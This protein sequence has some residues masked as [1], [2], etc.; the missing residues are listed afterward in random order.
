MAWSQVGGG[1]LR[2]GQRGAGGD[3]YI[4][5]PVNAWEAC[6]D[7]VQGSLRG[8]QRAALSAIIP[9]TIPVDATTD[10]ILYGPGVGPNPTVVIVPDDDI[11]IDAVVFLGTG[12]ARATLT[13]AADADLIT[14]QVSVVSDLGTTNSLGLV[15]TE[16][17]TNPITTVQPPII[18]AEADFGVA[19]LDG[20]PMTDW[21]D[22]SGHNPKFIAAAGVNPPIFHINGFGGTP[23]PYWEFDGGMGATG[24]LDVGGQAT[25]NHSTFTAFIVGL[26]DG[27]DTTGAWYEMQLAAHA[28]LGELRIAAPHLLVSRSGLSSIRTAGAPVIDADARITARHEFDGTHNGH[29]LFLNGEQQ[30]LSTFAGD[31]PGTGLTGPCFVYLG[32]HDS[33]SAKMIGQIAAILFF[34]PKLDATDTG[35]VEAYLTDKYQTTGTGSPGRGPIVDLLSTID[36][37]DITVEAAALG[38]AGDLKSTDF[39]GNQFM[40]FRFSEPIRRFDATWT[41]Q[42]DLGAGHSIAIFACDDF[43]GAIVGGHDFKSITTANERGTVAF[44]DGFTTVVVRGFFG[45]DYGLDGMNALTDCRFFKVGD[46]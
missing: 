6:A 12:Y 25:I 35:I 37:V 11:T 9:D 26:R 39:S 16:P 17:A 14:R 23:N 31:N 40:I 33:S 21:I 2:S 8:G 10:V 34:T 5:P 1:S 43:N 46:P 38:P 30:V 18:W 32:H 7:T 13:V 42:F 15:L 27:D 28:A 45:A 4:P 41:P 36:D 19:E 20:E 22:R 24:P 44:A 29:K 3:G